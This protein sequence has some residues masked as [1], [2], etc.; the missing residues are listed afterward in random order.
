MGLCNYSGSHPVIKKGSTGAAVVHAQCLLRN[1]HGHKIS[2][3]GVF[4]NGTH[5]AVVSFQKKK[6]L[7]AD[8]IVGNHT[9]NALHNV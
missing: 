1:Y 4:G 9:W 8:G 5:N 2:V 7:V 6:G 3:D